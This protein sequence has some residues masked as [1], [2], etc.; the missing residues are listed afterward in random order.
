MP[1]CPVCRWRERVLPHNQGEAPHPSCRVLRLPTLITDTEDVVATL[2]KEPLRT[3]SDMHKRPP[4]LWIDILSTKKLWGPTTGFAPNGTRWYRFACR[5]MRPVSL[6]SSSHL[7]TDY[8]EDFYG[9]RIKRDENGMFAMFKCV[10]LEALVTATLGSSGSEGILK[11]G[12]MRYGYLHDDH[13]AGVYTDASPPWELFPPGEEN[14]LLQLHMHANI[15]EAKHGPKGRYVLKSEQG[16]ASIG[17]DCADSEVLAILVSEDHVPKF[18]QTAVLPKPM[19]L[20]HIP[21]VFPG[22]IKPVQ[23]SAGARATLGEGKGR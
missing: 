6:L 15:T 5:D 18:L 21:P 23:T 12:G 9:N 1:S 7:S 2:E 10:P 3:R 20:C 13:G 17:A 14:A 11:D 16:D 22:C 19:T 4:K 8:I